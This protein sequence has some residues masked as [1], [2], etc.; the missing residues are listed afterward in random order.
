MHS[1]SDYYMFVCGDCFFGLEKIRFSQWWCFMAWIPEVELELVWICL[2][3]SATIFPFFFWVLEC[4]SYYMFFD[5]FL[6][7]QW[8]HS[9]SVV[10]VLISLA[11]YL[12]R[13]KQDLL[14]WANDRL[15]KSRRTLQNESEDSVW[16]LGAS[17]AAAN[18]G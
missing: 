13:M 6:V 1:S 15:G 2:W 12:P 8:V 11:C 4:G 16:I 17:F 9:S 3:F 7:Y 14:A 10:F 18:V 5:L